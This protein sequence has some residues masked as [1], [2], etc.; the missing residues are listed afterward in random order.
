MV[1]LLR[2]FFAEEREFENDEVLLEIV[3][4]AKEIPRLM[5]LL[6]RQRDVDRPGA[7]HTSTSIWHGGHRS[8]SRAD[9][10]AHQTDD[11]GIPCLPRQGKTA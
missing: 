10:T 7:S 3:R 11:A 5:G 1:K 4:R 2:E 9:T 6:P 8:L